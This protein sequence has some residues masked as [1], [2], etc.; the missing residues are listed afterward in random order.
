LDDFD[1]A[2]RK[3]SAGQEVEVVVRRGGEEVN[4]KATLAKPRS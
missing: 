1:L 2:L 4:L 3:F